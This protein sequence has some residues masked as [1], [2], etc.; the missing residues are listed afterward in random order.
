ML[1]L[2]FISLRLVL[3]FLDEARGGTAPSVLNSE[4]IEYIPICR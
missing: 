2:S 4:T 1:W 3:V